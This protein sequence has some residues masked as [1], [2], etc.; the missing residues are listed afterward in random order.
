MYWRTLVRHNHL[1]GLLEPERPS[2][3]TGDV[4]KNPALFF[5]YTLIKFAILFQVQVL[6]MYKLLKV[7]FFLKVL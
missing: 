1:T 6:Y 4:K 5:L 3:V 2:L 7:Y